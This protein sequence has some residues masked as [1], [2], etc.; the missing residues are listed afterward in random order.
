MRHS[1]T[2]VHAHT[3][4]HKPT[5]KPTQGTIPCTTTVFE[6]RHSIAQACLGISHRPVGSS[7]LQL[8]RGGV[9]GKGGGV[10]L[11]RQTHVDHRPSGRHHK[12]RT[13][14]RRLHCH[15]REVAVLIHTKHFLLSDTLQCYYKEYNLSFNQ[16]ERGTKYSQCLHGSIVVSIHTL[17]SAHWFQT[18][19][20]FCFPKCGTI[21]SRVFL[22]I[23]I[24]FNIS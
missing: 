10:Y 19:G 15:R 16:S 23:Y 12:L 22:N 3:H 20:F 9:G 11:I 2:C 21:P 24:F 1:A 14:V 17:D 6:Q 18:V 7:V 5:H 13:R 8:H 4:T